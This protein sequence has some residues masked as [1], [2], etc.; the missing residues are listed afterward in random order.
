MPA[1][2]YSHLIELAEYLEAGAAGHDE[3]D[4]VDLP[5][6]ARD[7]AATL[8]GLAVNLDETGVSLP[9]GNTA[10]LPGTEIDSIRNWSARDILLGV[11]TA[12]ELWNNT[13]DPDGVL[14]GGQRELLDRAITALD[15]DE[16]DKTAPF[17]AWPSLALADVLRAIGILW[18]STGGD[19]PH[20][21]LSSVQRQRLDR[22]ALLVLTAEDRERLIQ[23][24]A[25]PVS[26]P[27][28]DGVHLTM[29]QLSAWAGLDRD[30]TA[31]ELELLDEC[32]PNS[33]VPDAI[34]T[35]VLSL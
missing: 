15:E 9:A 2:D 7:V 20:D 19:D 24:D 21:V 30:L 34:G 16:D 8:R 12:A 1:G 10:C 25:R 33:S 18:Q 27:V 26:G 3:G 23:A 32:I 13:G 35:I 5:G 29:A 28:P 6:R 4:A 17:R 11:A 22:A 14:S 31:D